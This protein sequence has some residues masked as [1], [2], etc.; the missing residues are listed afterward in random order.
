MRGAAARRTKMKALVFDRI[1][2]AREVLSLRD[3]AEPVPGAGEVLIRVEARPIHPADLSFVRGEY[4]IRPKL[5][6]VAGLSGAGRVVAVGEGVAWKP[7]TRAAFR[8]PG[9]WAELVAVPV[10]RAIAAPEEVAV[11]DAAQFPLNPITAWGLLHTADAHAPGWIALTAPS[12]SVAQLVAVLA[13]RRGLRTVSVA[14][15]REDLAS[16]ARRVRE[17]TG[18]EG[19]AALIDSVGGPVVGQ[20]LPVLRQG[21]TIV[22]YGALGSEP[23]LVPNA[24]MVYGNLTWKGFGIDRWL[25]GLSAREYDDMIAELWEAVRLGRLPL[26]VRARMPLSAFASALAAAAN[27]APGKV[28]LV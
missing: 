27:G 28:L 24:A 17:A 16:L 4:R 26:P 7:G 15:A 8:W 19:L 18:G 13:A 11:E 12:S 23:A 9:A 6:Q 5:P 10:G 21:A 2:D 3:I 22:A 20:L 14:P 25:D 1:G